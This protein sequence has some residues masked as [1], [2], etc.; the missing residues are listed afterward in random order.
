LEGVT[1][2]LFIP[3]RKGR[4]TSSKKRGNVYLLKSEGVISGLALEKGQCG[5]KRE[6]GEDKFTLMERGKV[7]CFF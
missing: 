1:G 3:G 2:F 6:G 5:R 7:G 4:N